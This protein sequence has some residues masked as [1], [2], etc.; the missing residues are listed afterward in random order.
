MAIP[1]AALALYHNSAFGG[2]FTLPYEFS[3]QV[4][5]HLGFFMGIS[6]P[7][8]NTLYHILFSSYRGLFYSAP[9]L[10]LAIPGAI[11]LLRQ[12]RFRAEAAACIAIVVLFVWLNASLVD[13]E[14]GAAMGARYLIPAI[15]FLA[16]L[17]IGAW[18][19]LLRDPAITTE[20]PENRI[21]K[22]PINFWLKSIALVPCFVAVGISMVGMLAGTAVNP[23]IS[24]G[25]EKPF[26]EA[27]YPLFFSGNLAINFHP[28]DGQLATE[29]VGNAKFLTWDHGRMDLST[30]TGNLISVVSHA[31]NAG[32][33]IGLDGLASLLPLAI[34]ALVVGG[35]LWHACNQRDSCK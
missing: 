33:L 19:A 12:H 29:W 27:F 2:P 3:T 5:R 21:S 20:F 15:P 11:L 24:V 13:W 26:E 35:W 10:L 6:L 30:D 25:T 4:H 34:Y 7:E 8:A 17:T 16:I 1:G 9:W 18:E 22:L 23:Q 32:K 14:G 31:T 28:V